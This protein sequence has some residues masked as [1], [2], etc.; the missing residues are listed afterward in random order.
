MRA[1]ASTDDFFNDLSKSERQQAWGMYLTPKKNL[2]KQVK[3]E[4]KYLQERLQTQ[5]IWQL[6]N[7]KT[8]EKRFV[9]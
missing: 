5:L 6:K 4:F 8:P 2:I 7:N 9:N 3:S 1:R